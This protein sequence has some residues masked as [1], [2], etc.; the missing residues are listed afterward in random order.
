VHPQQVGLRPLVDGRA[1]QDDEPVSGPDDVLREQVLVHAVDDLFVVLAG[2]AEDEGLYAPEQVHPPG[3]PVRGRER[4]D[5]NLWAELRHEA[6]GKAGLCE[7]DDVLRVQLFGSVVRGT[8]EGIG[9]FVELRD[10][11]EGLAL[12]LV[13]HVLPVRLGREDDPGH[14]LHGF[15]GIL[16]RGRLCREHDRV[17]AVEDRVRHVRRFG[18]GGARV[19]GH[20]LQH[21]RGRDGEP[22]PA[23][24]P[25]QD[26]LLNDRHGLRRQLHAEVSA[27]DHHPIAHFEDLVEIVDGLRFLQLRDHVDLIAARFVQKR[28][29]LD[30]VGL[31]ADERRGDV[32]ELPLHG[33]S[34]I[35]AILVRDRRD[36]QLGVGKVHPLLRRDW[37]AVEDP[38][39]HALLVDRRDDELHEPVVDEDALPD[40]DLPRQRRERRRDRTGVAHTRLRPDDE[41]PAGLEI[42]HAVHIAD[43][44]LRSLDVPDDRHVTAEGLGHV[45]DGGDDPGVIVML[46]MG[47]VEAEG[48]DAA[49]EQALDHLLAAAGR[50]ERGENFRASHSLWAGR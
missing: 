25:G 30:D 29:E 1:H 15:D 14:H 37:A 48:V 35:D 4:D 36:R 39:R 16:P 19:R 23:A 3:H 13:V 18:A 27:R 17:G 2:F 34:D 45:A 8:G 11:A 50:T 46:S 28:A 21:L 9:E 10:L 33:E 22:P 26:L 40:A 43:A 49:G 20:R 47:E 32:V 12:P 6:G 41:G 7:D 44:Q 42:L 31:A 38:R 5:G 24:G